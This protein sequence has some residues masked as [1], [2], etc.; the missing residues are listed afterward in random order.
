[1]TGCNMRA[2]GA[3]E[4]VLSIST[5]TLEA[6]NLEFLSH[7]SLSLVPGLF[8]LNRSSLCMQPDSWAGHGRMPL[9]FLL[10]EPLS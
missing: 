5:G 2:I 1:M 10:K 4:D 9:G 3:H 8:L 7:S 6:R